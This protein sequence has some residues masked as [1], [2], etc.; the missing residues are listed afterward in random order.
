MRAR[1]KLESCW[2]RKDVAAPL[3]D[4][5]RAEVL[6]DAAGALDRQIEK[7]RAEDRKSVPYRPNSSG[8]G[9]VRAAAELR[10]MAAGGAS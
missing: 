6:R 4:A 8:P 10:R 7:M 9:M 5:Y 1:A 2:A 3:L